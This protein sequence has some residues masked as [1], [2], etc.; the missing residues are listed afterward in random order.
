MAIREFRHLRYV[1][2][3]LL[4]SPDGRHLL[5]ALAASVLVYLAYLTTHPLPAYGAGLYLAMAD[6]VSGEGY[7]LPSM[8]SGYTAEGIPFA[9]PPLAFY[10]IAVV[11]D[12]TGVEGMTLARYLPGLV[13]TVAVVPTYYLSRAVLDTRRQAAVAA[14]LASTAPPVLQWHL[15]AGGIVRAPAYVFLLTGLYAGVRLFRDGDR[16]WLWPAVALFGLTVLTH[17]LY[18]SAF[19]ISYL[20]LYV[21]TNRTWRGLRE[22]A[23]VAVGGILIAAPWLVT[24]QMRHGLGAVSGAAGTHGGIGGRLVNVLTGQGVSSVL[25]TPLT[26]SATTPTGQLLLWLWLGVVVAAFVYVLFVRGALLPGWFLVLGVTVWKGRFGFLLG[27][28]VT[29]FTVLDGLSVLSDRLER[30]FPERVTSHSV[31]VAAAIV[32]VV[33]STAAGGLYAASALETHPGS[34]SQPQYADE[35]DVSAMETISQATDADATFVVLGDGAEWFPY[36][37]DRTMLTG[38]WGVEWRGAEDFSSEYVLHRQLSHCQRAECVTELLD[39]NG[40]DPDYLYVPTGEHTINGVVFQPASERVPSF[41][42]DPA[43]DRVYRNDGVVVFEV[44]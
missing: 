15:S 30:F 39:E 28:M 24:V 14:V 38:H 13:S 9:Y 18:A 29:A 11:Q 31:T 37:A 40:L 41:T 26:E 10:A 44:E 42:A 7:R 36:L 23:T 12:L 20:W 8:V 34:P 1:A 25:F 6:A 4:L 33:A 2:G 16:S 35:D 22:G 17:P 43:Y 3:R 32:L 19:A 21:A 5:P 27:A